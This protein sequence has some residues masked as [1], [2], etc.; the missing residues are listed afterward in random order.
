M[1]GIEQPREDSGREAGGGDDDI[2]D[3][4][5]LYTQ[6]SFSF[7]LLWRC[8]LLDFSLSVVSRSG[9]SQNTVVS[10]VAVL[11]TWL[12]TRL[13]LPGSSRVSDDLVS[14]ETATF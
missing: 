12:F 2:D 3:G 10:V 5:D 6:V 13:E 9:Q 8:V 4:G 14:P 7:L 11:S 1:L